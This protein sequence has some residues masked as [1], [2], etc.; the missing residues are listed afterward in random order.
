MQSTLGTPHRGAEG[1]MWNSRAARAALRSSFVGIVAAAAVACAPTTYQTTSPNVR[2]RAAEVGLRSLEGRAL[3]TE[4]HRSVFEVIAAYWPNVESPPWQLY[5]A[6][7]TREIDRVGVFDGNGNFLGGIEQLRSVTAARVA[8][9][10][11]M[12]PGEEY[13][14]FGRQHVAGALIIEWAGAVR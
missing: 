6:L 13:L 2:G 10:R 1:T 14:R 4:E 8:R 12:T 11:R 7:P 3:S 9:V 5:S